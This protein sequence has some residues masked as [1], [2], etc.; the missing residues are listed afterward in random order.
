M[1]ELPESLAFA[2]V[3]ELGA[4]WRAGKFS[5]AGLAEFFLKRLE[6]IGPKLNA[7]VTLTP[8]LARQQAKRADEELAA[9]KDRGPLFGIPY[10]AKDLLDTKDI[11]TTWGAA[12]NKN[13]IPDRDATVISKLN[14]AGAVLVAKLAMVEVAGGL[15]YRQPNASFTGPARNPWNTDRWAGGSSSGSGAAVAAGL[16]PFAIGSETWGSIMAPAAY[17]GVTGLRPTYGRVSRHG[18]MALSWTMDK[19]GSM[20]RS[21]EDCG[22]VL[23]AIAGRD[24][25]DAT[26]VSRPY[27]FPPEKPV[28]GPFRFAAVKDVVKGLQPEVA[29]NYE[30]SL[31]LLKECGRIEEIELPELPYNEVAGLVISCEMASAFE[32][33]LDSRAVWEMTAEEDRWGAFGPQVLPAVDYLRAMR[34]RAVIQREMDRLLKPYDALVSPTEETVAPPVDQTF[35]SYGR[36]FHNCEVSAAGNVS[37][38]PAISLPNGF[39]EGRLPTALNLLGRA[40]EENRLLAVAHQLQTQTP[41]HTQAPPA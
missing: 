21:A 3:R 23:S 14:D 2:S 12:P 30:A 29:K 22:L 8:D 38:L 41:W 39:G 33:L 40:F 13:R 36:D 5:A 7:V 25:Q 10:G 28:S 24:P 27:Q 34:V 19:L 16:V 31:K 32:E 4:G 15:G 6:Q 11:P 37:G 26:S 9:G 17:C 20:A 35:S 1:A 18:A